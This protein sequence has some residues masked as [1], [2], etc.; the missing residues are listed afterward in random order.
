MKTRQNQVSL[1]K[2]FSFVLF[3]IIFVTGCVN[4]P[5]L[6]R[7]RPNVPPPSLDPNSD[8]IPQS[9]VTEVVGGPVVIVEGDKDVTPVALPE[10]KSV[11]LTHQV[12]KGESFWKIAKIYGVSKSELAACNNLTL[13]KP[14]KIGTM[15]VIPPGG[16]AGYKEPPPV[17]KAPAKNLPVIKAKAVAKPPAKNDGSYTVQQGDSLWKISRK[18]NISTQALIDA[19]GIDRKKPIIPGMQLVIPGAGSSS[20]KP[21]PETKKPEVIETIPPEDNGAGDVKTEKT[22]EDPLDGLLNDAVNAADDKN[23]KAEN[24][25]D[26]ID[27]LDKAAATTDVPLSEDLYTEEVLPNETLQEIAERHGLKVEDILK[28]NPS[29]NANQKLQPFTSIKIP[30]KK[31]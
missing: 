5:L 1:I 7:N 3:L 28:V 17:K 2:L 18:F 30:N 20:V 8:E 26:V 19:N 25:T 4:R 15:L 12:E 10:I 29:L 14:L 6:L 27:G 16:V 11:P 13:E 21:K 23:T 9:M 22:E 31:Y 24:P